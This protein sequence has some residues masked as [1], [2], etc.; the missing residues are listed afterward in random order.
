MADQG[1]EQGKRKPAARALSDNAP[2]RPA[3]WDIEDAG[4]LQALFRGD[5]P[6]HVQ[7]RALK[8]MI[9][10]LCGTYEM[11]YHAGTDGERN[12]AFALGRAFPGQQIVKLLKVNL[13]RLEKRPSEQG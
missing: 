12:T 9:E 5:A 13:A 11:H 3:T 8:F 4:A 7:Q 2:W 1:R 10:A 6:P